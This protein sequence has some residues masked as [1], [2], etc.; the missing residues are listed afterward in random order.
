MEI[1]RQVAALA[2]VFGLLWAARRLLRGRS[3]RSVS[4]ATVLESRGRLALTS[5]HSVHLIRVG[6]RILIVGVHPEG[7]T[8]LGDGGNSQHREAASMGGASS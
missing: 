2:V 8:F 7:I 6:E 4:S 3:W 5:R 1:L